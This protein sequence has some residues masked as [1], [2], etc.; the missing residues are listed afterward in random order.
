MD[1]F[2][3][4]FATIHAFGRRNR[5]TD[6]R[7]IGRTPFSRLDGV[8]NLHSMQLG[9]NRKN[10]VHAIEDFTHKNLSSSNE[11]SSSFRV[12]RVVPI[13]S[14]PVARQRRGVLT[15]FLIT[16]KQKYV[17]MCVEVESR[18]MVSAV[19]KA[20]RRIRRRHPYRSRRSCRTFFPGMSPRKFFT[21]T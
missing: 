8:C 16:I 13:S 21:C 15:N 5:R 12:C 1:R 10:C 11:S 18:H 6:R 9:K 17:F 14:F 2:F 19:D 7:T 20:D 3:F 4:R